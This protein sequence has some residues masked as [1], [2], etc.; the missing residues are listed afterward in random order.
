MKSL[1]ILCNAGLANRLH[2]IAGAKY[3][4]QQTGRNLK[5]WWP[6]NHHLGAQF[7]RLFKNQDLDFVKQDEIQ[8][9]LDN[10]N[11][12]KVYN[13]GYNVLKTE[14]P[15]CYE[16]MGDDAEEIVAI[17]TYYTPRFKHLHEASIAPHV[18]RFLRELSPVDE[19]LDLMQ[20]YLGLWKRG[21]PIGLHIRYGDYAPGQPGQWDKDNVA[22]YARSGVNSFK[23][24]ADQILA[25]HPVATFFVTSINPA[26][27]L[28]LVMYLNETNVGFQPKTNA[29]RHTVLGMREAL[30][31]LILLSRCNFIV[32]SDYSQ[33]T[34]AA[35][36]LGCIPVVRAGNP[37][38]EEQLSKLIETRLS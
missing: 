3:I 35:A 38:Y 30:A 21:C 16:V 31:D 34:Q 4:A 28:E 11:R 17:K 26:I 6:V 10:E 36:E 23:A 33:F 18:V 19:V 24:A 13:C 14:V 25:Q 37:K 9:L 5:V 29:G 1:Y 20:P 8:A 2:A 12:V 22:L 32:G 27:E 7:K 15:E